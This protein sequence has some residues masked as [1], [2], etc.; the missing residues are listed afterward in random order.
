MRKIKSHKPPMQKSWQEYE[1]IWEA[2]QEALDPTERTIRML[3][4]VCTAMPFVF[5]GYYYAGT[6]SMNTRSNS[7]GRKHRNL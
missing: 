5:A 4:M 6:A 3:E 1:K 7:G 2:E